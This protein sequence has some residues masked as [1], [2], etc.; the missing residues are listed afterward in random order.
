M[1]ILVGLIEHIG[2]II[3]CE[4]VAR[5]L[6]EKYHEAT[7]SWVVH[8]KYR[9]LIDT[10]PYIDICITVECLTEW[11]VISR[12]QKF[13]MVVDLHVNYRICEHCRIPLVKT[14][15]DPHVDAYEWFNHGAILEAFSLGAGLP[16]I[17][18][19]P[20]LYIQERHVQAVDKL[21][22]GNHYCVIH[23]SSNNAEKDWQ[24]PYWAQL[25]QWLSQEHKLKVVEVGSGPMPKT[26]RY[27]G[28]YIM[29]ANRTS[30]METAEVIRRADLFIGVDSGPAHMANAVQ[31]PGVILLG[32]LGTFRQYTPF[33]GLYASENGKVKLVR[34]LTGPAHEI[35]PSDVID[36]VAYVIQYA[37]KRL[38]P[39]LA[40]DT[41]PPFQSI[42]ATSDDTD[43]LKDRTFPH[44]LAFYLPQFHP[45]Q[46]NNDAHGMGFTEW[47]NVIKAKP[48]FRGHYQPKIP[49]ELSFYDLRSLDVMRQQ[50]DLAVAHGLTGFCFYYYY[51]VGKRLLYKPIQNYIESD[52]NFPF[53]LLW[54]NE[55]WSKQWDGGD[56]EVIIRQA[57]SEK[58]DQIFLRQ[59]LTVFQD[60][61][62]IKVNGCPILII[63][64]PHLFNDIKASTETWRT[65]AEKGGFPGLYL[66]MA[67]DWFRHLYHP[68]ELGFDASY[69]IPS[70]LTYPHMCLNDLSA[71]DPEVD[72]QGKLVDYYNFS[73][74]FG[75]RPFPE[76]KRFKTVM[77]PW[78]NTARYG[79]NALV[80]VNTG[81]SAYRMWLSKAY[82]D[83][84]RHYPPEERILFIHSWN[85]WCEGTHIEPD[86]KYGRRYLEQT[87][88][89]IEDAKQ[90]IEFSEKTGLDLNSASLINRI[91]REKEAAFNQILK[92][93][94]READI[95]WGE[96]GRLQAVFQT[97]SWKLTRP[98]RFASRVVLRLKNA[99]RSICV[100]V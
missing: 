74:Y 43:A 3:A 83:T 51:F 24:E 16:K 62:Y 97:R 57:H 22:L 9:E 18:D 68:R 64:K 89:A 72:F 96:V 73:E 47:N 13:D 100:S 35:A 44:V 7:I 98:L 95:A 79:N 19:Q 29:L 5:Y 88:D 25:I 55:N 12:H 15:G 21:A 1:K 90:V 67:D 6:R 69:E 82:L 48:L 60:K 32:R 20:R 99:I 49:G 91:S 65:E 53:C 38:N 37:G 42:L 56:K 80:H 14:Q 28:D 50:I 33:T 54:A 46:E 27:L 36:A 8:N 77:A 70:N 26:K 31:T 45:I 87:R 71:Y 52:I 63:Y 17:S 76:Y 41:L 39:R 10:N 4:P 81:N 58:D 94:R 78:D 61:R 34:N 11:I 93:V 92:A 84:Y 85:E 66:I 75:C 86:G 59:L 2:D 40:T 30:L 23:R